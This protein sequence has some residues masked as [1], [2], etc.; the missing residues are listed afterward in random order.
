MKTTLSLKPAEVKKDWVLIDAEGVVLGR[1]AALVA[2]RLRGKHKPQFTPHVDCGDHVVIVNADKVRLTGKKAEQAI[3]YY[4]T[5]Y[6]GGIKGQS[7]RQRLAGKR[8]EQVVEKA[9]ERMITR[10]PLQRQQMRNLHV[11]AGAEHPHAG[12]TPRRLDLAALN[13]KNMRG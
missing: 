6:P 12:Q 9:I 4:H 5:G 3:F 10:G 11:Y 7:A 1:L 2:M 13:P 8:P